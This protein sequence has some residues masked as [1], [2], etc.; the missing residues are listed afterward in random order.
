MP[1][2]SSSIVK[3]QVASM[4]DV[5]EALARQVLY[6]GDLATNLLELAAVSEAELTRLLA[7]S[8]GLEAG[9]EGELPRA[10]E[11]TLRLVPGDLALRHGLYPLDEHDGTLVV[12]VSDPLPPE[13]EQDWGSRWASA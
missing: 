12:A 13:V 3:Q 9:P 11:R 4:R 1:T 5:Q 6:G 10:E 7:E 2:L 8:H